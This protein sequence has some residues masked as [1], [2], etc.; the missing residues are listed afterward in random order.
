MRKQREEERAA[1]IEAAR[2]QMQREEEAE[3][4]REQ[5]KAEERAA[6]RN[7]IAARSEA[8]A[9]WRRP[10]TPSRAQA[11]TPPRPESPTPIRFRGTGTGGVVGGGGTWRER[12]ARKAVGGAAAGAPIPPA[13][14][15]LHPK[16]PREELPKDEDGFQPVQE[17][18]VWKP[19]RLQGR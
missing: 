6:A 11:A 9:A 2:L 15:V 1:A 12:E 5:R 17:K 13:S 14:P 8:T 7:P 19:K 4:H 3:R 10:S 16:S 18:K